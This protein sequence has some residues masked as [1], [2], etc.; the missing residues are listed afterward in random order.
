VHGRR[1]RGGIEN[2]DVLARGDVRLVAPLELVTEVV[3]ER[4][5]DDVDV[6]PISTALGVAREPVEPRLLVGSGRFRLAGEVAREVLTVG[7]DR[8]TAESLYPQQV[9]IVTRA[10]PGTQIID[11]Q[12]GHL[13]KQLP[14]HP[15]HAIRYV[16]PVERKAGYF[17]PALRARMKSRAVVTVATTGDADRSGAFG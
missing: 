3:G 1:V 7:S 8:V 13:G 15:H 16:G 2:A 14:R 11:H 12:I 17:D 9:L 6:A 4:L 10:D 5:L